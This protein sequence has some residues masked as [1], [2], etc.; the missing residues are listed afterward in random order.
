VQVNIISVEEGRRIY[1]ALYEKGTVTTACFAVF[2]FQVL[3]PKIRQRLTENSIKTNVMPLKLAGTF[4]K[5]EATLSYAGLILVCSD[6]EFWERL[7]YIWS[8][9]KRSSQNTGS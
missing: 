9:A 5:Y 6:E 4:L 8:A 7:G 2:G 1:V 3:V